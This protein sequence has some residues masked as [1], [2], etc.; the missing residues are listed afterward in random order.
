MVTDSLMPG[1]WLRSCLTPARCR[2]RAAQ[3]GFGIVE[4]LGQEALERLLERQLLVLL[5]AAALMFSSRCSSSSV[6]AIASLRL[7]FGI[8]RNRPML[9]S[10]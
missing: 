6:I 5:L 4:Q 8:W 9:V 2:W 3:L 10:C 1:G 7:R